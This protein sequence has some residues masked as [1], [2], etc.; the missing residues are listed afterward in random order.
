MREWLPVGPDHADLLPGIVGARRFAAYT[1]WHTHLVTPMLAPAI[2]AAFQKK[3]CG[4]TERVV[5]APE[6]TDLAVAVVVHADIEP[7]FRHP[8][9]MAHGSR[10]GAA[11]LLRSAPAPLD[12]HECIEQFLFPI[13]LAPRFTPGKRSQGR[14]NEPHMVLLDIRIP[15]G[16]FNSPEPEHHRTVDPEILLDA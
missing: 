14:K 4:R 1:P 6:G 9:G 3:A 7:D 12:D 8:L 13:F 10:P 16:G 2:L 5:G 11:H 15:I